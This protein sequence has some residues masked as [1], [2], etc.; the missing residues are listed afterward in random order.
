MKRIISLVIMLA[1]TLSMLVG[2]CTDKK[3]NEKFMVYASIYPLYDF[4]SK[5]GGDKAEVNLI[6]PTGIEPHDWEP[7]AKDIVN[8]SS[9]DLFI[10]NG[11]HLEH[12]VEDVEGTLKNENV[13][14]LCATDN[15]AKLKNNG[16]D[17]PHVWLDPISAIIELEAIKDAFVECDSKNADYYTENFEKYKL[18]LEKLDK[19]YSDALVSCE[20]K[21]IVT[22][23]RAFNYL[24]NRYGLT[25]VTAE[26]AVAESEPE[27]KALLNVIKLAKQENIKTVFVAEIGS[28]KIADTI[29]KEIAGKV[30]VL[31]NLESLN[32]EQIKNG[33]DYFSVM[34]ENL[35]VL[36]EVLK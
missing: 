36:K 29:A 12:W 9:A 13:T 2:C 10:Y 34:R 8:L 23:H 33:D 19:E 20:Q 24:C 32:D 31:Y 25:Q 4:A 30:K 35:E 1:I 27:A 11:A 7:T 28:S 14:I 21:N 6:I 18:E 26:G 5:I 15:V 22:V 17:D 16:E 3:E